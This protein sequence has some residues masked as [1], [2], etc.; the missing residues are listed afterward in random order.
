MWPG[1]LR[2]DGSAMTEDF[3]S[4][5]LLCAVLR[6]HLLRL[7]GNLQKLQVMWQT[8]FVDM[9]SLLSWQYLMRDIHIIKTWNVTMVTTL[10]HTYYSSNLLFT[11]VGDLNPTL[12]AQ[13][14]TLR[15]E[16]YR[17]ALRNLEQ[18]YQ[19][20]LRDS[21]DSQMFGAED[22]MQVESNYNGAN[23]HYNTMVSTAEQGRHRLL[24]L[25]KPA[26]LAPSAEHTS[27]IHI[28]PFLME[29]FTQMFLLTF[30]HMC[31][32]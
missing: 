4:E 3:K 15:V 2:P 1:E 18:H 20:F 21:Q 19:D 11:C 9:K 30:S 31:V 5:N 25:K 14:K 6:Q 16:E 8:L 23:Q 24:C 29:S 27:N 10:K 7:D 22:R 28:Q 17:L 26:Y 12:S 32:S 13:F